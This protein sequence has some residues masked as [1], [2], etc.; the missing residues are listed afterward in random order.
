MLRYKQ[1]VERRA[2]LRSLDEYIQMFLEGVVT[3]TAALLSKRL[4]G[5]FG[6]F[7]KP[8]RRPRE[9]LILAKLLYFPKG[10]II[11][12][13]NWHES[14]PQLQITAFVPGGPEFS[15]NWVFET[16]DRPEKVA[17]EGVRLIA[18][19]LEKFLEKNYKQ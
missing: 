13:A 9:I 5:E 15:D 17:R 10:R 2:V 11:V 18:D 7:G 14:A 8:L 4:K 6:T 3:Q 1:S 19:D 16:S 12:V